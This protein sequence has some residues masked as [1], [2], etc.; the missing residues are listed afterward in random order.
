MLEVQDQAVTDLVSGVTCGVPYIVGKWKD[1]L[2]CQR[3]R[4]V[5]RNPLQVP[6]LVRITYAHEDQ[7]PV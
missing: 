6:A 1:Q 7:S 4:G 2:V 3:P 5:S